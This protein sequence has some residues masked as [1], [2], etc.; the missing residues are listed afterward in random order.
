[1]LTKCLRFRW[2][3]CQLDVLSKLKDRR[4][5][6]VE[7][8]LE[9]LPSD[10][11]ATYKRLL[12]AI[13]DDDR[14]LVLRMLNFVAL[15]ARPVTLD[16]V[17][18]YAIIEDGMVRVTPV[19]RFANCDEILQLCGNFVSVQDKI[20]S[21]AHKS[22]KDF[23]LSADV[24][25]QPA[26][27]YGDLEIEIGRT[28]LIY[29][30]FSGDSDNFETGAPSTEQL[31][32][33]R[34]CYPFLEYAAA[35]WP[36][37]LRRASHQNALKGLM[38][39]S[40]NLLGSSNLWKTW[41]I[42]Q[43]ADIWDNQIQLAFFLCDAVIRSPDVPGWALDFWDIRQ[44]LRKKDL[45]RSPNSQN[46]V[47]RSP[48]SRTKSARLGYR[49]V[50]SFSGQFFVEVSGKQEYTLAVILLEVALQKSLESI[51]QQEASLGSTYDTLNR[52]LQL[53]YDKSEKARSRMGQKYGDVV[54]EC[55]RLATLGTEGLPEVPAPL[56]PDQRQ[57]ILWE[58]CCQPLQ[59]IAK[60]GFA[61]AH[62][63]R[64]SPHT[65]PDCE[66]D[67]IFDFF[68]GGMTTHEI[69]TKDEGSEST[70]RN[71]AALLNG[72]V[73]AESYTYL[74]SKANDLIRATHPTH[75]T[76]GLPPSADGV[77]YGAFSSSFFGR[78]GLSRVL[79]PWNY[80]QKSA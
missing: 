39:S 21:L 13:P 52:H 60:A 51:V 61:R 12:A 40:L 18:E 15:C 62:G 11:H 53:L 57:H 70:L 24:T 48:Q 65:E 63:F 41:L 75:P 9:R 1:V 78:A 31:Q 50:Q 72:E 30:S 8:A 29:L 19:H 54:L 6:T 56:S 27:E 20:L 68:T 33:L 35:M 23:L 5:V 59:K 4:S 32:R 26:N 58:K 79:Q 16:E 3:Q 55:I 47:E 76:Y 7:R 34:V 10:L 42:L 74:H 49:H 45:S 77:F 69:S 25:Q 80:Q 22:V 73:P 14:A 64:A 44:T 37:H 28:C 17:A 46:S 38:Q 36:H 43:P 67:N 2:A 71:F 66:E